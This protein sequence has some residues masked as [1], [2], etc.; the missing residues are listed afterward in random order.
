[1]SYSIISKIKNAISNV[2]SSFIYILATI[3]AFILIVII[4]VYSLEKIRNPVISRVL[5]V[6]GILFVPGIYIT[7]IVIK[8]TFDGIGLLENENIAWSILFFVIPLFAVIIK[9]IMGKLKKQ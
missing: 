4:K 9:E 2:F 8:E 3:L 1:M 6:L 7:C 5:Y